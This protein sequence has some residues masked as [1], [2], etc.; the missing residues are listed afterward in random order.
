[1]TKNNTQP[2]AWQARIWVRNGPPKIAIASRAIAARAASA[3]SAQV[4]SDTA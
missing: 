1:L 2:G 4:R 3:P